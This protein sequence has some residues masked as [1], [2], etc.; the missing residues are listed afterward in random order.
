[1]P[2]TRIKVNELNDADCEFISLVPSGANGLPFRRLKGENA[3]DFDRYFRKQRA[4]ASDDEPTILAL[5]VSDKA[6]EGIVQKLK[7]EGYDLDEGQKGNDLTIYPQVD[8]ELDDKDERQVAYKIH[9]DV[10]VISQVQKAFQPFQ[11]STS[12]AENFASE[13][14]FPKASGALE[15]FGS[16]MA[17][18]MFQSEDK[19]EAARRVKEEGDSFVQTLASLVDSLPEK[20]FKLEEALDSV[21]VEKTEPEKIEAKP[22]PA[23]VEKADE[24]KPEAETVKIVLADG[25]EVEGTLVAK[26]DKDDADADSD[27]E[28]EKETVEKTEPPLSAKDVA[29]QV[30]EALGGK[31]DD[32]GDRLGKVE[33]RQKTVDEA[34]RGSAA[35]DDLGDHEEDDDGADDFGP[36]LIDTGMT[37][38]RDPERRI[39]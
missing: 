29:D 34:V 20:V 16:T 38:F 31:I 26:A 13:G 22:E 32:L 33:T 3:M 30:I 36:A 1:M 9:P 39:L 37:R 2:K 28:S 15:I 17:E 21:K 5:V 14:F 23:K 11:G 18:I 19:N 27:D 4:K 10:V 7:D 35:V 12:F 25:T 24:E 8:A 6:S